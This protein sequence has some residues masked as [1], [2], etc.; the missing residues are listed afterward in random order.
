M[1]L[2]GSVAKQD[3]EEAQQQH[4]ADLKTTL[5]KLPRV[6][7]CVLDAIVSHLNT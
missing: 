2:V 5:L 1:S 7:L 3:S 6:H 4:F